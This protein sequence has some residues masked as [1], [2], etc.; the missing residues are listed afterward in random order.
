MQPAFEVAEQHGN[1]LDALL[2]GKV[3]YALLLNLVG[4]D[5]VSA[6]LLGFEVQLYDSERK[7]RNSV[8][9]NLLRKIWL[10]RLRCV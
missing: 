3:L 6:L 1:G 7:L 10:D 4:R 8:D 2:V 9:M 5:A